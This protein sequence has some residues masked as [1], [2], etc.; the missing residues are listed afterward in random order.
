MFNIFGGKSEADMKSDTAEAEAEAPPITNP[1]ADVEMVGD[2]VIATLTITELSDEPG[3][4]QLAGL[5]DDLRGSGARHFVLDISNVQFMNSACLG[6]LV[7]ALNGMGKGGG[8][9]A[10]VNPAGS[11][12]SL[13]RIT[14]LDSVFLIL[15][16]VPSA[17]SIIDGDGEEADE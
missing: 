11:V 9:I 8:R 2:V 1:I 10:L 15:K 17:L 14:R 4:T 12:Q 5:L 7:E 16:D 3:A 6:C 13:F